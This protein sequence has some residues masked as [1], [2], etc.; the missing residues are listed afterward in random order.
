VLSNPLS[1]SRG[2]T[3]LARLILGKDL[4]GSATFKSDILFS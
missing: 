3:S 1:M 2:P 4:V